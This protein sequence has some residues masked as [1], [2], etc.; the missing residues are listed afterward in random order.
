M[1]KKSQNVSLNLLFYRHQLNLSKK[2]MATKLGLNPTT[3][4]YYENGEREPNLD[5][6]YDMAA[7]LQIT[8]DD[9]LTS[10]AKSPNDKWIDELSNVLTR[11]RFRVVSVDDE[12]AIIANVHG[13]SIVGGGHAPTRVSPADTKYPKRKI[14]LETLQRLHASLLDEGA[15]GISGFLK[16]YFLD[17]EL[18]AELNPLFSKKEEQ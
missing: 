6:L 7:R 11:T 5:T 15:H 17:T 4:F 9:L 8:V 14:E 2:E 1:K 16:S 18:D 13:P 12:T 10:S 3:Y